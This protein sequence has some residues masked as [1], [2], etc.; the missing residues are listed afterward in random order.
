M[1]W[2]K[3]NWFK[4]GLLAVFVISVAGAF[5]WFEWRPSQITRQCNKEAVEKVRD[6][7]DGNQAIKIYDARYKSCLRGKG[8]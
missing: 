6:V 2:L 8:L 3:E 4:I 5:Y 1:N 7:D